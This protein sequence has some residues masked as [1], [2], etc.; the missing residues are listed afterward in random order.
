MKYKKITTEYTFLSSKRNEQQALRRKNHVKNAICPLI[1]S[2]YSFANARAPVSS[3]AP[4]PMAAQQM[5][6]MSTQAHK[7]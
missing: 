7:K 5:R 4:T 1:E 6:I 3:R 2:P